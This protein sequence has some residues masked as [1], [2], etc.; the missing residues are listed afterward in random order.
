VSG[1][2]HDELSVALR[3]LHRRSGEPSTRA[4]GKSIGYSHAT[5]AYTLN[6]TRPATWVVVEA[7]VVHL[8]GDVEHFRKLW[9]ARR[10]RDDPL[11][12]LAGDPTTLQAAKPGRL[13]S[14]ADGRGQPAVTQADDRVEVR[15]I[16]GAPTLMLFMPAATARELFFGPKPQGDHDE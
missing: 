12:P 13:N 1:E 10:D 14:A 3:H 16:P 8:G 5:V 15:G 4:I 11:P 7:I 6:G 2:P 9:I